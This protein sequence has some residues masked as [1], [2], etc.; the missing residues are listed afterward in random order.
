MSKRIT[1]SVPDGK[2][3]EI[4]KIAIEKGF[5]GTSDLARFALYQY[6]ARYPVKNPVH[7]RPGQVQTELKETTDLNNEKNRHKGNC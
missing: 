5:R 2:K 3:T 1:F 4:E 7:V 6:L